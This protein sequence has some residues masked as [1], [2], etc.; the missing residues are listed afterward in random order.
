MTQPKDYLITHQTMPAQP[1]WAYLATVIGDDDE[2]IVDIIHEPI[3]E[4]RI[5]T[6]R[7]GGPNFDSIV[8]PLLATC[9]YHLGDSADC[10]IRRPDASYFC[11]MPFNSEC[12]SEELKDKAAL[13]EYYTLRA[14]DA[15]AR[16]VAEQNE[17]LAALAN[18]KLA[19]GR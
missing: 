19:G 6:S 7:Y 18:K 1:G 10:V 2:T 17:R 3:I 12:R 11:S 5:E 15:E 8:Y 13:I 16:R 9:M 4:W 14:Q